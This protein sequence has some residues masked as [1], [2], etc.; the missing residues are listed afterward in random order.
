[1]MGMRRGALT[2]L[3]GL[4]ASVGCQRV[5][6]V[7][8][9]TFA[10]APGVPHGPGIDLVQTA[11]HAWHHND[12]PTPI[13]FD[14]TVRGG[15][16]I[17]AMVSTF[18]GDSHGVTDSAADDYELAT[19]ASSKENSKVSLYY[20]TAKATGP[21]TVVLATD[22][23]NL[24]SSEASLILHDYNGASSTPFDSATPT[25]GLGLNSPNEID[26]GPLLATVDNELMVIA[27][28]HDAAVNE[29]VN[30]PFQ[31]EVIAT[32]ASDVTV[33][34]F[35]ADDST[36]PTGGIDATLTMTGTSSWAAVMVGFVPQ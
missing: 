23:G 18:D 12:P 33:P 29:A 9:R 15:D 16:L 27:V 1:M 10:D 3:A 19:T 24:S 35:S 21:L 32:D 6:D 14:N 36:V 20:A 26:V 17:V 13:S 8:P 34:L 4:V 7:D 22:I 25:N 11:S 30:S 31:L 5:F 28:A 2:V